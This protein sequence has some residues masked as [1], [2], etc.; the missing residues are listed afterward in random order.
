MLARARRRV[1]VK[2]FIRTAGPRPAQTAQAR[3]IRGSAFLS[4]LL[5]TDTHRPMHPT[6]DSTDRADAYAAVQRMLPAP[7]ADC[8]TCGERIPPEERRASPLASTCVACRTGM[9]AFRFPSR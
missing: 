1:G 9:E 2:Q 8:D 5:S 6:R 3:A 7:P 4:S